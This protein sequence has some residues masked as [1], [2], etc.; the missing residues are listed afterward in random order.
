MSCQAPPHRQAYCASL[1]Q[2]PAPHLWHHQ[3]PA[4]DRGAGG[5]TCQQRLADSRQQLGIARKPAS[6]ARGMQRRQV[7]RRSRWAV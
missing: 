4:V 7:S 5:A 6:C 2:Q 3:V 1:P